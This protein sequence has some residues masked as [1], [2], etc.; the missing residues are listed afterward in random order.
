LSRARD[1]HY[2]FYEVGRA[3]LLAGDIEGGSQA[4][5]SFLKSIGPGEGGETR[6][7][8]HL[9]LSRVAQESGNPDGAIAQLQAAVEALPQD[10]RPYLAMGAFL[11]ADGHAPEAIEVLE[12]GVK[13]M[14]QARPDWRMLQEL[15]LA[16]ADAGQEQKAVTTIEQ[17]I[18]FLISQQYLDLPPEAAARLARLHEK[19]GN[20]GRAADLFVM[21]ARGSDRPNHFLYHREAGRLLAEL[22]IKDEARRMLQRATELA[23]EDE[24]VRLELKAQLEALDVPAAAE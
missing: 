1:P 18:E 15:G 23:P 12:A 14:D 16:F 2:L 3:R 5:D 22:G 8:A 24:K 21:L 17:A 7:S 20:K 9:E 19:A 10:P 6:L 4:L 11:R 13:A